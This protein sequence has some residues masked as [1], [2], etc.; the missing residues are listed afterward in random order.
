MKQQTMRMK[1]RRPTAPGEILR[2]EFWLNA[3]RAVDLFEARDE[4]DNLPKPL[5]KT[6]WLR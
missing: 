4:M 3:Q 6:G 2:E 1:T 5:L